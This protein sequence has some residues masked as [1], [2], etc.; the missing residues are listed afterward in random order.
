[1]A[2][3]TRANQD[4]RDAAIHFLRKVRLR[5]ISKL[6]IYRGL[7]DVLAAYGRNADAAAS[8][9]VDFV[10]KLLRHHPDLIV[11]FNAFLPPK[12]KI[13]VADDNY[14]AATKPGGSGG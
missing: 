6:D 2:K 12:H 14:A 8:P 13:K 1:M 3:S 11:D 9:V 10:A 7:I 4:D 5:F